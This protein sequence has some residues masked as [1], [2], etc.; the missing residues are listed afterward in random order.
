MIEFSKL[1]GL[2]TSFLFSECWIKID[3]T[4]NNRWIIFWRSITSSLVNL[5]EEFSGLVLNRLS[6]NKKSVISFRQVTKSWSKQPRLLSN[7]AMVI[8]I[9]IYCLFTWVLKI[10]NGEWPITYTL[11]TFLHFTTCVELKLRAQSFI[12]IDQ[13]V[14]KFVFALH[15]GSK[16]QI[17]KYQE[18]IQLINFSIKRF[19]TKSSI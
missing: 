4:A 11:Y 1:T 17:N 18:Q 10:P 13:R 8:W 5:T 14:I 15:N 6:Y 9:F 7:Q 16:E 2:D 12:S 19:T 3:L